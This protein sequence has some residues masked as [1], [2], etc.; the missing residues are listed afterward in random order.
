MKKTFTATFLFATIIIGLTS[1]TVLSD[2]GIGG[3]T[4]S[5]GETNCT[6]CHNS[7]SV[8]TGGGSISIGSTPAFNGNQYTPGATYTI[9]ITV[10]KTGVNLFGFDT[11]ILNSSNTNAGTISVISAATTRTLTIGAKRN[12]THQFNGGATANSKT[13]SFKWVA[14][15]SGNATIYTSGV[16][17]N[18]NSSFSLDYVYNTSLALTAGAAVTGIEENVLKST[19]SIYPNPVSS[20]I[21]VNYTLTENAFVSIKLTSLSGALITELL[22]ETQTQGDQKTRLDIPDS[23]TKGIYLLSIDAGTKKCSKRIIIN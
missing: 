10:S 22:N 16:A 15:A 1:A 14:P 8:N 2:N 12:I 20:F 4:G 19:I 23:V 18:G 6:T 9:D 5:P 3:Y 7:F 21:H 13:F 11:E 17:A